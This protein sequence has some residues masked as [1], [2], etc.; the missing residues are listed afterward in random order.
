MTS[1]VFEI[2]RLTSIP[3]DNTEHKVSVALVDLAPDFQYQCVPKMST[4]A[5]LTAKVKNTSQYA[6]LPGPSNIFLDNNFV[7]KVS[8]ELIKN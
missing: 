4:F 6:F 8:L 3:S 5:Y 7:S 2:A 1:A